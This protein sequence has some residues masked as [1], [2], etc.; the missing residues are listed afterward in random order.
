MEGN[1]EIKSRSNIKYFVYMDRVD[2]NEGYN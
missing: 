1:Y 2:R